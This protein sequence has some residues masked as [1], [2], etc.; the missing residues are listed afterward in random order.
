MLYTFHW[1][2]MNLGISNSVAF[3][4]RRLLEIKYMVYLDS[5]DCFTSNAALQY[6]TSPM[7]TVWGNSWTPRKLCLAQ[8]G[9]YKSTNREKC[10]LVYPRMSCAGTSI[11]SF[12]LE[13]WRDQDFLRKMTSVQVPTSSKGIRKL[14]RLVV[15]WSNSLWTNIKRY[16]GTFYPFNKIGDDHYYGP[17]APQLVM[18]SAVSVPAI[19]LD[20]APSCLNICCLNICVLHFDKSTMAVSSIFVKT[21]S[22]GEC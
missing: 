18:Q 21:V 17:T 14:L 15:L 13:H 1:L 5:R 4:W 20:Q 19:E 7:H 6:A 16:W 10:S 3:L 11:R 2:C 12:P 9:D 8:R 22:T